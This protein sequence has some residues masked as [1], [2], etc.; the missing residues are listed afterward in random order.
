MKTIRS[1][2]F[3]F[4][5]ILGGL[6]FFFLVAFVTA[7]NPTYTTPALNIDFIFL[8]MGLIL[9]FLVAIPITFSLPK[10]RFTELAEDALIAQKL[11]VF[12]KMFLIKNATYEGLA[13]ASIAIYMITKEHTYL[14]L[15]GL[16]IVLVM[17]TYP[18]ANKV[19]DDLSIDESE[20]QNN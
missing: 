7:N 18:S 3:A 2:K 20:L 10:K 5:S 15:I 17:L 4:Y 16:V 11:A 8:K 14:Y 19:C 12:K 1:L 6:A 13:L 9:L